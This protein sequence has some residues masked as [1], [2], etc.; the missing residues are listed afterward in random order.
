MKPGDI[1][2]IYQSPLNETDCDGK[3]KLIKRIPYTPPGLEQWEVVFLDDCMKTV[4][5]IK[6]GQ[7][8]F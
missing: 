6:P 3:A 2:R 7:S 1:V 8:P 4:R 5:L